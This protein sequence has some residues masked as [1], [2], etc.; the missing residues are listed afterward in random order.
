MQHLEIK[1]DLSRKSSKVADEASA[2]SFSV[3]TL[4]VEALLSA[5]FEMERA[6]GQNSAIVNELSDISIM[7]LGKVQSNQQCPFEQQD[8]FSS[9][10]DEDRHHLLPRF[11]DTK[12]NVTWTEIE[13]VKTREMQLISIQQELNEQIV[14]LREELE[15][16]RCVQST[17]M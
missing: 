14:Y 11:P 6:L 15:S 7:L 5:A 8:A 13:S 1:S 12:S 2:S 4:S 10:P 3:L 9:G 16:C 17:I